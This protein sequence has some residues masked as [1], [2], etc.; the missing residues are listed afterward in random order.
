MSCEII[1]DK[2]SY[3][4]GENLTGRVEIANSQPMTIRY[5]A[6]MI[7]GSADVHWTESKSHTVNGKRKTRTVIY[8]SQE[9]YLNSRTILYGQEGGPT[10]HLPAGNHSYTFACEL[11]YALPGSLVGAYGKITYK[12]K[13]KFDIPWA[14]DDKYEKEFHVIATLDL[15]QN[16]SLR[17]PSQVE[18]IKDYCSWKCTTTPAFITVTIPKSGFLVNEEIPISVRISNKSTVD[19]VSI[20]TKLVK[21]LVC[22]ST[23]PNIKER[24]ETNKIAHNTYDLHQKSSDREISIESK[25]TV[26]YTPVTCNVSSNIKI[27]YYVEVAVYVTGCHST[28]RVHVPVTIGTFPIYSNVNS[29][30]ILP[31]MPVPNAPVSPLAMAPQF[32]MSITNIP[33][34]PMSDETAPPPSYSEAVYGWKEDERSLNMQSGPKF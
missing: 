12:A 14:F 24:H 13:V 27:S 8:S 7:K 31:Q 16:V 6:L 3:V 28:A 34:A 23:T 19:I 5:I 15:S 11:P 25:L 10:I 32:E 20:Q 22:R 29:N 4:A 18:K 2:T 26:P 33:T 21:S 1:L 17:M 30:T 9:Q